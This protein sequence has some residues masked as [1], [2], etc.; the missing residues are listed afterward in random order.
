MP[1]IQ[2]ISLVRRNRERWNIQFDDGTSVELDVELAVKEGIRLGLTIESDRL[3]ELIRKDELQRA[4]KQALG[5]L[6]RRRH[7]RREISIKLKQKNYPDDVIHS[8]CERL[9]KMGKLDPG[10]FALV[11]VREKIKLSD[12]GPS[13]LRG[14]LRE[15]GVPSEIA[16]KILAEHFT[17]DVQRE[18]IKLLCEKLARK[19]MPKDRSDAQK[20]IAK[21]G[22]K[23]YDFSLI[24]EVIRD[25]CSD[26]PL[27]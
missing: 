14:E 26:F 11:Y 21:I 24:L 20:M 4:Y 9:E 18:K 17:A 5:M 22:R 1:L 25:F 13:R 27:D 8:V 12:I 3:E 6:H 15:R 7:T 19:G 16:D 23:G 2:N 10:E